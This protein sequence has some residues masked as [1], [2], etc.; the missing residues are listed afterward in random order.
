MVT[1]EKAIFWGE[2]KWG[3]NNDHVFYFLFLYKN[4]LEELR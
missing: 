3:K 4:V 2:V 1:L